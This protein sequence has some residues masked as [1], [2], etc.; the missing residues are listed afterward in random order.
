MKKQKAKSSLKRGNGASSKTY[1][2][3]ADIDHIEKPSPSK[4]FI[5]TTGLGGTV[6]LVEEKAKNGRS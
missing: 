6:F 5:E 4:N 2:P 3:I 1:R